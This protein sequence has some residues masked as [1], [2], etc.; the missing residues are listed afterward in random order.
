MISGGMYSGVPQKVQVLCPGGTS[1]AKPRSTRRT[2]LRNNRLVI[3]HDKRGK[4]SPVVVDHEIFGLQIPVAVMSLVEIVE[5]LNYTG[6]VKTTD[7]VVEGATSV[8]C[9]PKVATKV[10]VSQEVHEFLV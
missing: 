9:T 5:S 3:S 7:D 10:R 6:D 8:K 2:Y 4:K 1:L